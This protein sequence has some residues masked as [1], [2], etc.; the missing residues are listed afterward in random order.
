MPITFVIAIINVF[1]QQTI[2]HVQTLLNVLIKE[3]L[4]IIAMPI[5][6][7][8]IVQMQIVILTASIQPVHF[9]NQIA[10]ITNATLNNVSMI[11][12]AQLINFAFYQ[13]ELVLL[14]PLLVIIAVNVYHLLIY[15]AWMDFAPQLN[16]KSGMTVH[17]IL[18][19]QFI[20]IPIINVKYALMFFVLLNV[21]NLVKFVQLV[22]LI[23]VHP[24]GIV[25][26]AM[27]TVI[28]LFREIIF[29][30]LMEY[31]N[32]KMKHVLMMIGVII[33]VLKVKNVLMEFAISVLVHQHVDKDIPL[34]LILIYTSVIKLQVFVKNVL[35]TQFLQFRPPRNAQ[36]SVNLQQIVP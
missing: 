7:A 25:D 28:V 19:Y 9:T 10:S 26:I 22:I 5:V 4:I 16:V 31:V 1:L 24:M 27:S 2:I 23:F 12:I 14:K 17:K 6:L 3:S 11:L 18:D 8:R 36:L 15:I 20:V 33:M 35:L 29:L 13:Q 32:I 34:Y 21:H 30:V